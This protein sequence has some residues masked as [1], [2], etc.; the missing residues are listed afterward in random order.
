MNE[1]VLSNLG[2]NSNLALTYYDGMLV[3]VALEGKTYRWRTPKQDEIGLLENNFQYPTGIVIGGVN[4]SGRL[5]NFFEVK[6]GKKPIPYLTLELKAKGP[7][8]TLETIQIGDLVEG[9]K[10][11]DVYWDCAE[12][13]GGDITD[14][15]NY[16]PIVETIL[17]GDPGE[18]PG[19]GEGE[20]GIPFEFMGLWDT[21]IGYTPNQ[22]VNDSGAL[23]INIQE[24]AAGGGTFPPSTQPLFWALFLPKG[25]DGDNGVDG[26][27][28]ADGLSAYEIAVANGYVGNIS[29]WLASLQGS[30]GLSAYEVAVANGYV[31]T[32]SAW[33]LSLKGAN[34]ANASNNLQRDVETSFDLADTDNNYVIQIKNGATPITITVPNSG[35]RT[36]FNVGFIPRGTGD[37]TFVGAATVNIINPVGL[38]AKGQG[39]ALYLERDGTTQDYNLLGNTKA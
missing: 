18:F 39:L 4:Y 5:F 30:N 13:L 24:T 17:S 1:S 14:R 32:Q 12:Y 35:M 25:I 31:G 20:S 16:K 34:G 29:A 37:V 26:A 9:F 22:I 28:G 8:N 11:A 15:E 23:Y 36:K 10:D 7:N 3:Y 33:L 27:D 6:Y 2:V 38:K 21:Q 19:G